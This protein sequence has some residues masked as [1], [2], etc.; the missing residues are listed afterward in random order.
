MCILELSWLVLYIS[1]KHSQEY[2]QHIVYAGLWI[3]RSVVRLSIF[4]PDAGT[5]DMK[6]LSA[7]YSQLGNAY[8]YLQQYE[9]AFEFHRLDLNLTR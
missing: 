7:I 3:F 5:D 8:F 2:F 1:I 6:V 9:K 4:I